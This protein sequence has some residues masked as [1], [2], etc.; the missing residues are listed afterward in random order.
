MEKTWRALRP[1]CP[2]VTKIPSTVAPGSGAD[3]EDRRGEEEEP[4]LGCLSKELEQDL[5]WSRCQD[6][7]IYHIF[8]NETLYTPIL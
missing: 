8:L 1:I 5:V 3:A 6:S 7:G 2:P 4:R